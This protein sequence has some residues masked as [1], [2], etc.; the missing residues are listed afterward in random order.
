M[1]FLLFL[2]SQHFVC[3]F[4]KLTFMLHFTAHNTAFAV[5]QLS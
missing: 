3:Y 5:L 1:L 2:V 4:I